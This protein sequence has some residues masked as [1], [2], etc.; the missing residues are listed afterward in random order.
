MKH[1]ISRHGLH[2]VQQQLA[3]YAALLRMFATVNIEIHELERIVAVETSTSHPH[4]S[5]GA[6]IDRGT[7]PF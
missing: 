1:A 5:R 3:F 7:Q 6:E 4:E 2:N